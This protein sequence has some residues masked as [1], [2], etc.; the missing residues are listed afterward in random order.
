MLSIENAASRPRRGVLQVKVVG[1]RRG[2]GVVLD[3]GL[4]IPTTY[5]VESS[6]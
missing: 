1:P 4:P 3:L 2:G 5:V 6:Y